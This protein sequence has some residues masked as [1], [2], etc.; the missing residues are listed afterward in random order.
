MSLLALPGVMLC[1][2]DTRCP[3]LALAALRRCMARCGFGRSVLFTDRRVDG[4]GHA[5]VEQILFEPLHSSADYSNF[6]VR[7]LRD[8]AHESHVLIG[9]WDCIGAP[10]LRSRDSRRMARGLLASGHFHV[11]RRL[12]QRRRCSGR[13]D[14]HTAMLY[15]ATVFMSSFSSPLE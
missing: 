1:A 9:Q 11:G 6:I 7:G 3:E 14:P 15:A 2:A 8:H 5:E 13:R 4:E 12:L 10:W